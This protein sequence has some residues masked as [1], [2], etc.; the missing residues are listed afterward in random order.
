MPSISEN[1]A[2]LK[3]LSEKGYKLYVLSNFQKEGFDKALEKFDFFSL[4][5]GMVV[6]ARIKMVKPDREIYEHIISQ[7]GLIPEE[8][9]FF[10]DTLNNVHAA[11][12]MGFIAVHT[13][14]PKALNDYYR[15][16]L[17]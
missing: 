9:V 6:S 3:N 11:S 17:V 15:N 4:F 5:D 14:T 7:F 16:T 2:V 10:D 8:S 13:P 1:V 12:K